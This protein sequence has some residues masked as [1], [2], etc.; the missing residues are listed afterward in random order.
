MCPSTSPRVCI[1][2]GSTRS[3]A[4]RS[5][6]H[7]LQI[8]GLGTPGTTGTYPAFGR[9]D[10]VFSGGDQRCRTRTAGVV[11]PRIFQHLVEDLLRQVGEDKVRVV[12]VE[13]LEAIHHDLIAGN[14]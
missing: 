9:P 3:P 4:K 8:D 2:P 12:R 5:L 10:L 11:A 7:Y 1:T 6:S 14:G 13:H